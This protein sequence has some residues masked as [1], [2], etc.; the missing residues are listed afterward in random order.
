MRKFLLFACSAVFALSASAQIAKTSLAKSAVKVNSEVL[1]SQA[2]SST[3]QKTA[4]FAS[5]KGMKKA[6]ARVES[7]GVYGLYIADAAG[8]DGAKIGCDSLVLS[9]CDVTMEGVEQHLNVQLT[10]PASSP[11]TIYGIYDDNAKT[12]TIPAYQFCGNFT[13]ASQGVDY[14]FVCV[15]L[16]DNNGSLNLSQADNYTLSVESDGIYCDDIV[17]FYIAINGNNQSY[18]KAYNMLEAHP[19]NAVYSY[20]WQTN[21]DSQNPTYGEEAIAVYVNDMG[22]M[23]SVHGFANLPGSRGAELNV[24]ANFDVDEATKAVTLHTP[25][26]AWE[27][28]MLGIDQE[29]IGD[30]YRLWGVTEGTGEY[31]GYVLRDLS[32]NSTIPGVIEGNSLQTSPLP[33]ASNSWKDAATG[34]ERRYGMWIVSPVVTL[35]EGNFKCDAANGIADVNAQKNVKAGKTFNVFGQ[36]VPATAKGL[37]IR[38]GKKFFNK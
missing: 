21:Q 27:L 13:S 33:M 23:V 6:P 20:K 18:W 22:N 37:V 1:N 7:D 4:A 35:N 29:G 34:E 38:D 26:D 31:E 17:G 14:Q 32:D 3:M 11:I 36:E 16:I 30:Y 15:G 24:I 25:M 2:L 28:A 8:L 9:K 10:F 5:N 19:A 12:I